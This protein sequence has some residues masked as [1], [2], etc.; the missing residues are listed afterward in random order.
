MVIYLDVVLIENFIIDLFL[1]KSTSKVLRINCITK[2]LFLAALLGS[3][4]TV[5]MVISDLRFL[6]IMPFQILMAFIIICVLF[7]DVGVKVRLKATGIF[8]LLSA[9][10]SGLCLFLSLSSNYSFTIGFN[11]KESTLKNIILSLMI[12]YLVCDRVIGYLRERT[13][14]NNFIYDVEIEFSNFKYNLRAF[15]DTGNELREPLTNLPCILV[16]EKYIEN[17]KEEEEKMYLIPYSAVGIKGT[18]KGIRCKSVKIRRGG[19]AWRNIE[20][21]I[22][23]CKEV[24]SIENDFNALLSR[25]II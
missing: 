2:R 11:L 10:L 25:G 5:T 1:L 21:I 3:I 23:P 6:S 16:E 24:F 17:C 7:K 9:M 19:E 13:F 14:I 22:C 12:L 20:A 4:Y 15:L 8:I 18:L